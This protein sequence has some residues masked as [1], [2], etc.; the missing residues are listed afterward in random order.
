MNPKSVI[1]QPKKK[2]KQT[3]KIKW[4]YGLYKK[5]IKS[6]EDQVFPQI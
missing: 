2:K 3:N 1:L 4:N 6:R 5:Y